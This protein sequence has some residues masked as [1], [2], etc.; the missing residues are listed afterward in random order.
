MSKGYAHDDALTLAY[1]TL[2]NTLTRQ[3][4]LVSYDQGFFMV[5]LS[6][7]L[8]IPVVLMIRYKKNAAAIVNADH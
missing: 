1:N 4:F 3:Q 8:C 7:L 5:G 6:I 2:E